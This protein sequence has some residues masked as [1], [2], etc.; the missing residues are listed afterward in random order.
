[1]SWFNKGIEGF[2]GSMSTSAAVS[3]AMTPGI[4]NA[5]LASMPVIF[6]CAMEERTKE[7]CRAPGRSRLAIYVPLPVRKRG[8]SM[9]VTRFPKML[10]PA[11]CQIMDWQVS[12]KRWV[13]STLLNYPKILIAASG[14]AREH[15][16]VCLWSAYH[17]VIFI[18]SNFCTTHNTPVHFVWPIGQTQCALTGVHARQ[19]R[20]L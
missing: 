9:R 8:S 14:W 20:P 19:W 2:A 5:S 15:T 10:T 3:T 18:A 13:N 16:A 4:D 11:F 6:A 17:G 1:M 12:P 7:I